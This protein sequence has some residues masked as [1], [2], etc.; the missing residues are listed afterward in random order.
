[1]SNLISTKFLNVNIKWNISAIWRQEL[2]MTQIC[3]IRCDVSSRTEHPCDICYWPKHKTHM[4]YAFVV[5][6][7]GLLNKWFS[8]TSK[9][10][11][12]NR[13]CAFIDKM[14]PVI[15]LMRTRVVARFNIEPWKGNSRFE[16]SLS[17]LQKFIITIYFWIPENICY[18][19]MYNI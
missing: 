5:F 7:L 18:R 2:T 17:V 19:M 3:S 4:S 12:T 13:K 10:I 1:M 14:S 15:I 6:T 9:L 8:N 11:I 16:K